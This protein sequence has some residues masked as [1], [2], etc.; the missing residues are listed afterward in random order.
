MAA[1]YT[2][3]AMT[4]ELLEPPP[5]RGVTVFF[6][7]LSGAGKSTIAGVLMSRLLERGRRTV[8][9]LDGDVVRGNL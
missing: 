3:I 6:T 5:R 1:R 7:G 2:C 4:Q 9:L 8:T